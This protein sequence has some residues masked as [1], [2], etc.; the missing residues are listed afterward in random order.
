MERLVARVVEIG[1]GD[2]LQRVGEDGAFRAAE[3][4]EQRHGVADLREPNLL[5]P[6]IVALELLNL[7]ARAAHHDVFEHALAQLVGVFLDRGDVLL[8]VVEPVKRLEAIAQL[9]KKMPP[10]C[11]V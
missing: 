11:G 7:A 1:A 5:L 6:E 2:A 8:G 10:D 9:I 4:V 3:L